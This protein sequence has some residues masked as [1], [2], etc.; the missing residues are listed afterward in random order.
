ME[1]ISENAMKN[2]TLIFS[3]A[4]EE[5]EKTQ[6][7]LISILWLMFKN[8]LKFHKFMLDNY[9]FCPYKKI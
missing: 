7:I 8:C 2:L 9:F 6:D 1:L 5:G 3:W 4:W